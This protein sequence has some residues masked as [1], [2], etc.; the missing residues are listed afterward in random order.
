MI[1]CCLAGAA[2]ARAT[3]VDIHAAL[4]RATIIS[5]SAYRNT[6]QQA[7]P[8]QLRSA[9]KISRSDFARFGAEPPVPTLAFRFFRSLRRNIIA[10]DGENHVLTCCQNLR[11]LPWR[12]SPTQG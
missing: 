8:R 3:L 9:T 7:W 2:K 4:L 6:N 5:T 1:L 12:S 11:S 10:R